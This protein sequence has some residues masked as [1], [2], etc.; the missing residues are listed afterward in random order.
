MISVFNFLNLTSTKIRNSLYLSL[1]TTSVSS[2]PLGS[3]FHFLLLMDLVRRPLLEEE[4][5]EDKDED[6]VFEDF[7]FLDKEEEELEL[8]VP[9]LFFCCTL[10]SKE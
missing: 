4:V 8:D 7:F 2:G 3:G 5:D 9:P 1:N 10:E 6:E